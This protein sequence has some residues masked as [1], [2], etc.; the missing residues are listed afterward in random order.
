MKFN[1]SLIMIIKRWNNL[2]LTVLLWEEHFCHCVAKWVPTISLYQ[3][4]Y[5]EYMSSVEYCV[6][7]WVFCHWHQLLVYTTGSRIRWEFVK[8]PATEVVLCSFY[9]FCTCRLLYI[10]F[11][12]FIIIFSNRDR[13][14]FSIMVFLFGRQRKISAIAH[15]I[16]FFLETVS[17]YFKHFWF[18]LLLCLYF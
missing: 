1:H 4:Q 9:V 2:P 8:E 10:F 18:C 5:S 15:V 16:S 6:I 7:M 14:N 12:L 17:C 3:I 13:M 11:T